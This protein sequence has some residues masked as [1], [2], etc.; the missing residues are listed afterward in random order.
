MPDK[1]A[2]SRFGLKNGLSYLRLL[3]DGGCDGG[4]LLAALDE[5][6]LDGGRLLELLSIEK[7]SYAYPM[8]R[9]KRPEAGF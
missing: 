3:L 6:R 4:N 2:V 9:V 1:K 8:D 5:A 7:V